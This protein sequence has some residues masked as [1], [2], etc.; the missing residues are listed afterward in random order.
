MFKENK[1]LVEAK[2]QELIRRIDGTR[3]KKDVFADIQSNL[4][5]PSQSKAPRE[6]IEEFV[7]RAEEAYEKGVLENQDVNW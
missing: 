5:R 4:Q 6:S 7:R 2:Y 3:P 1:D